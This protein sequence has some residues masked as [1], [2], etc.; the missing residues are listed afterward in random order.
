MTRDPFSTDT[1]DDHILRTGHAATAAD[2]AASVRSPAPSASL[3][4]GRAGAA[5]PDGETGHRSG[6]LAVAPPEEGGSDSGDTPDPF[7][8]P[9]VGDTADGR[10][11]EPPEDAEGAAQ[12]VA[13][14]EEG[15]EDEPIRTVLWT[16]ATERPLDE[17]AA[18]VARLQRTGEVS[19]PADVALRAAAVSRP[20]DEVRQLVALLK[21]SGHD[22]HQADTTLRAAAVGR[23]VDDVV[24]LVS[25]LG[26][27]G[28]DR[29]DGTAGGPAGGRRARPSRAERARQKAAATWSRSA[30]DTAL[31]SGPRGQTVSPALR[32]A[33]R[34]PA[35]LALFVCGA[36]HL[37]TDLGALR[38]GGYAETASLAVL[39][40]CLVCA[41]WLAVRDTF[42][43]WAASAGLAVGVV[44]LHA[45]A[46]AG[47]VGLLDSSLGSAFAWAEAAAVLGAAAT[48]GLACTA[49]V[50]SRGRSGGATG[51]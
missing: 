26:T 50:R 24:H 20:V 4:D 12:D 8:D 31:A 36:I 25:I 22:L 10:A 2:A 41:V 23:P 35:A 39:A 1:A 38:S 18:L 3:S 27:D 30:L 21:E 48:V 49:M 29:P 46:G 40:L 5:D 14:P 34:W 16:A 11:A 6:T 51:A 9:A 28:G 44:A 33:L 37:P 19:S 47:A 15:P 17:V 43:V 32:S 13:P 7:P 42:V 45:L